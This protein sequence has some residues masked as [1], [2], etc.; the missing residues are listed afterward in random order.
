[1]R[2]PYQKKIP[3][4]KRTVTEFRGLDRRVGAGEASFAKMTNMSGEKKKCISSRRARGRLELEAADVYSMISTDVLIGGKIRENAFIVDGGNRLKAFYYE[5]GEL[6][7]TDIMNT[8]GFTTGK[9]KLIA[10][11]GYLYFFPDKKYINLMNL[12]ELGSLE[13]ETVLPIGAGES[14]YYDAVLESTDESGENTMDDSGYVRIKCRKYKYS[15]SGVGDYLANYNFSVVFEENDVIDISGTGDFDGLYKIVTIPDDY[16]Y[17][18]VKGYISETRTVSSGSVKLR[19]SVPDMDYVA[20]AGNRLWGC[21]YGADENGAPVN[22]IYASRLGDAK[23]WHSFEGISTDSYAASLGVDGVFTG[24]AVYEGDPLFFKEDAVIRIYGSEPS[25]FTVLTRNIRGIEKGSEESIVT[26]D[27]MLYYKTYSGIVA[28][29]GGMPYNVDEALGGEKYSNAVAGERCG[30]YY[31]S[32]QNYDGE[33]ELFVYDT[34]K[35]TWHREDNIRVRDFCRCGS[36]LYML[37]GED[38]ENSVWSVCGSGT[39][40]EEAVEWSCE[41]G[42]IDYLIPYRKRI[43]ALEIRAE[44]DDDAYFKAEI[45]YNGEE[46]WRKAASAAGELRRITVPVRPRRCDSFRLRFSGIGGC[47]LISVVRSESVCGDNR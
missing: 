39:S 33:Y 20:A 10:S 45:S 14:L 23:N 41:T 47:R 2:I 18:V 37:A 11:G 15:D 36:E 24:A 9:N 38:G 27:D 28:Y 31:V 12:K 21:R 8:T 26:V 22:E 3:E 29:N 43:S 35:K 17:I 1:M 40:S 30:K 46:K 34:D 25:D 6:R 13:A 19:R 5:N 42:D 44:L 32:M 4:T 7:C 16:N